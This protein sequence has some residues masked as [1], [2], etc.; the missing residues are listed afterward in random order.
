MPVIV[1]YP[2]VVQQALDRFGDNFQ[3]EPERRHFA[4]Y[5]TGLLIARKKNVSAINR[6]FA[7]TTDQSCLNRFVTEVDWDAE[8][9]KAMDT[10]I[11]AKEAIIKANEREVELFK[12]RA[13]TIEQIAEM[14]ML[15]LNDRVVRGTETVAEGERLKGWGGGGVKA[16][17]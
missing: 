17:R 5:L 10:A 12:S 6:E 3:N 16:K 13:K 8:A 1:Q 15:H 9:K 2:T 14:E 7:F 11:A 4:E